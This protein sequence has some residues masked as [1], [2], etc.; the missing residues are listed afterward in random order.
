MHGLALRVV[1]VDGGALVVVALDLPQ[2]H[3]QVVTELAKLSFAG[4]LKA[5][6]ECWRKDDKVLVTVIK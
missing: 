5:E 6:L 3:T 2:V 1:Q 4:V